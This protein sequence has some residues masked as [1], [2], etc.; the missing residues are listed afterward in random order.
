MK[1]LHGKSNGRGGVNIVMADFIET[2]DFVGSVVALNTVTVSS[3]NSSARSS[4]AMLV[5]LVVFM[6]LWSDV[7]HRV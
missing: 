5:S 6:L 2:H 4:P 3:S 1:W 7:C